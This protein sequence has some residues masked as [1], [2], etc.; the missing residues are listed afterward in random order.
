MG[1]PVRS[2]DGSEALADVINGMHFLRETSL[3][4]DTETKQTQPR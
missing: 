1:E 3:A 4:A 2:R